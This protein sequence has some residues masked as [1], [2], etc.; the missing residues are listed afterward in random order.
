MLSISDMCFVFFGRI[1]VTVFNFTTFMAL[2]G[3]ALLYFLFLQTTIV[4]MVLDK[5][6]DSDEKFKIDCMV[7]MAM[8]IVQTPVIL[9]R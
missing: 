8:V 4:N 1:C 6:F 9:K 7:T 2:G 5:P 3:Y